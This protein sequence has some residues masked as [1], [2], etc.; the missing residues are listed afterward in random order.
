MD[1][2]LPYRIKQER[3][4]II[5]QVSKEKLDVFLDSNIGFEQEV[6]IEKHKDKETGLYKGVTRNY[7]DVLAEKAEYNTLTTLKLVRK[8]GNKIFAQ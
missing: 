4:E 6:L 8:E 2:H 1:G 5:K 3:A 7:I